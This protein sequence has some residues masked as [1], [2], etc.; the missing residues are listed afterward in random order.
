MEGGGTCYHEVARVTWPREVME[1][2]WEPF[3]EP[4]GW[5]GVGGWLQGCYLAFFELLG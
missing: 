4:G 2:M 1:D 3:R 5:G